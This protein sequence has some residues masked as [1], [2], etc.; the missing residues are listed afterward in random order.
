[1]ENI[2][3]Q[4]LGTFAPSI[5]VIIVGTFAGYLLLRREKR[6]A[7]NH[8][9]ESKRIIA[10]I[11]DSHGTDQTPMLWKRRS[12]CKTFG[13]SNKDEY[14]RALRSSIW[15]R[16]EWSYREFSSNFLFVQST[17]ATQL[18]DDAKKY[19]NDLR[20]HFVVI[21]DD[22]SEAELS[23]FNN[24]LDAIERRKPDEYNK[25]SINVQTTVSPPKK[26]AAGNGIRIC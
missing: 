3:W 12:V 2:E 21:G 4:R 24:I 22:L 14:R 1:M 15:K 23:D 9:E 11:G 19:L 13:Y 10:L 20:N 17:A 26:V 18:K 25:N 6:L 5:I 8:K 16:I 7:N